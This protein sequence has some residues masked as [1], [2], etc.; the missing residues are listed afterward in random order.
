MPPVLRLARKRSPER[1]W[2]RRAARRPSGGCG[3]DRRGRRSASICRSASRISSAVI[4]AKSRRCSTSRS[5]DG[6][7]GVDLDL[8]ALARR[9]CRARPRTGPRRRARRRARTLAFQRRFRLRREH[10][11]EA[12][13]APPEQP[14]G[15]VE[16]G[17]M[18]VPLHEDGVQ[19]P[20]E[21]AA[22][23]RC[24]RPPPR[25]SRRSPTTDRSAIPARRSARPKWTMFSASLPLSTTGRHHATVPLTTNWVTAKR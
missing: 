13:A 23:R 16:D 12:L 15:L 20:V 24:R 25:G 9:R 19:R 10:L 18:V 14:E 4:C 11:V 21:I 22:R 17:L 5:G 3:R 2:C 1:R 6:E 7:A 8:V